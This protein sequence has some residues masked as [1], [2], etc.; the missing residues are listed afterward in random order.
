MNNERRKILR[1]V[2]DELQQFVDGKIPETQALG[3]LAELEPDVEECRFIETE[4]RDK[5]EE[6]F[7]SGPKT[8]KAN[9]L[10]YE[11]EDAHEEMKTAI[12]HLKDNDAEYQG[13]IDV[14][15]KSIIRHIKN[16]IS[17]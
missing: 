16:A 4:C 17:K 6:T 3:V 5:I 14:Y 9:K 7:P 10:L 12:Q 1:F 11:L 13:L 2:L 15:I 8:E